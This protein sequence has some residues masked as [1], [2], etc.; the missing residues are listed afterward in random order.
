MY[1]RTD[2][3][4]EKHRI[5]MKIWRS[6]NRERARAYDRMYWKKIKAEKYRIKR[7]G[8]KHCRL[9]GIK[10]ASVYG[11]YRTRFYCRNCVDR[12]D[13]KKHRDR[14]AMKRFYDKKS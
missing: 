9:C 5:K 14:L 3:Q 4:R 10:L 12:G 13:A 2:E 8:D 7:M 6:E 1:R 11:G